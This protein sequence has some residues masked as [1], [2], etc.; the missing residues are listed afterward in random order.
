MSTKLLIN[1]NDLLRQRTVESACMEFRRAG[2]Q[3]P[4]SAPCVRL[5]MTLKTWVVAM[6]SV[7][8]RLSTSLCVAF[9]LVNSARQKI[10][11]VQL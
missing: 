10:L 9:K 1:L 2:T 3:M 6:P 7:E 4:P 11:A 8:D 5:R